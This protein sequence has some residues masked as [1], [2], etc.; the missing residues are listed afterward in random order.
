MTLED[1]QKQAY[2]TTLPDRDPATVNLGTGLADYW[3]RHKEE[4]G[5]PVTAELDLD[6]GRTAQ[7]FATGRIL[8]YDGGMIEVL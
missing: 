3:L 5:T 8:V 6:D 1:L 4:L 7:R 2:V